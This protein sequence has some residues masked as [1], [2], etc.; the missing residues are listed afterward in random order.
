[1]NKRMKDVKFL[2][3][4]GGAYFPAILPLTSLRFFHVP[5]IHPVPSFLASPFSHSVR[6]EEL[7]LKN[8]RRIDGG[9]P[10]GIKLELFILFLPRQF[11]N[12]I[13]GGG[14]GK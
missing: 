14:R 6:A 5:L 9:N 2:K 8:K 12:L 3:L 1:M 11:F 4:Y 10:W 7:N 13:N